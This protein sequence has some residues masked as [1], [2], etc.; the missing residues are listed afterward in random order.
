MHLHH[1]SYTPYYC[2]P[3]TQ[4]TREANTAETDI[5]RG[6]HLSR[7]SLWSNY[8]SFQFTPKL[9]P[10][11]TTKSPALSLGEKRIQGL[12]LSR[13]QLSRISAMPS[14]SLTCEWE[15]ERERERWLTLF[16]FNKYHFHKSMGRVKAKWR[17]WATDTSVAQF[18]GSQEQPFVIP[19]QVGVEKRISI[20]E[21]T[22]VVMSVMMGCTGLRHIPNSIHQIIHML[23]LWSRNREREHSRQGKIMSKA[24]KRPK[25]KPTGCPVSYWT[26]VCV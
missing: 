4:Y 5:F 6:Q 11:H 26:P 15:K 10:C 12:L 16:K 8:G 2:T 24:L 18:K 3:N 22:Y 17:K 1:C 9:S 14:K 7:I 23:C 19:I 21:N 25:G 20:K 13:L